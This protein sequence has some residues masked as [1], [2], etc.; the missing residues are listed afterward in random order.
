MKNDFYC[1]YDVS[2]FSAWWKLLP[3]NSVW[4]KKEIYY[5]NKGPCY[6]DTENSKYCNIGMLS[7]LIHVPAK[8]T[9][10]LAYQKDVLW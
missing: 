1:I 3:F 10:A 2:I 9:G 5:Q 8:V 7:C 4:S 6:K